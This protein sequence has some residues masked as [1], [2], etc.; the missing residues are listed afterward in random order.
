MCAKFFEGLF[1]G[2]KQQPQ[3]APPAAVAVREKRQ[4]GQVKSEAVVDTA[5]TRK[6]A[7]AGNTSIGIAIGSPDSP[8]KRTTELG[9]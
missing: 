8:R 7:G 2:P 1:G 3:A 5:P 9:L 4:A 6:V